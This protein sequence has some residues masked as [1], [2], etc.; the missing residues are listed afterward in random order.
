MIHYEKV[1]D[2]NGDPILDADGYTQVTVRIQTD[3]LALDSNTISGV[4]SE[5]YS[6]CF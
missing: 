3:E 2:S 5:G 4:T 6:Y 1:V